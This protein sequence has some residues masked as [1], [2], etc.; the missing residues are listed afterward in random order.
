MQGLFFRNFTGDYIPEIMK[1]IYFERVYDHLARKDMTVI[2]IGANQGYFTY[3]ATLKGAKKV[4]SVEPSELHQ[5]VLNHMID[6]NKLREK[7][8]PI[9]AAISNFTG[10]GTFYHNVNTTMFSLQEAVK[11]AKG[12]TEQ[13]KVMTLSDLF[14]EYNIDHVDL[15]KVDTEGEEFKIFSSEA[16]TE[17]APK[18]DQIVVEWHSWTNIIGI[19]LITMLQDR[20]YKCDQIKTQATVF[21]AIR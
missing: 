4:Y 20:G 6:F 9:Q 14:K 1:E 13:V 21:T 10:T 8:T 2:D 7:V 11:D 18:I 15:M 17:V 12:E 5:E 3:W 16:F 19:Q